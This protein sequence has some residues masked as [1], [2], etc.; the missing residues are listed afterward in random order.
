MHGLGRFLV[1]VR[2]FQRQ[3]QLDVD[4]R[5]FQPAPN[6]SPTRGEGNDLPEVQALNGE[7]LREE[8]RA[9]EA[10]EAFKKAIGGGLE[11]ANIYVKLGLALKE[12]NQDEEAAQAMQTADRLGD[13]DALS[14]FHLGNFYRDKGDKE[15]RAQAE[16]YY[17]R[18]IVLR[19]DFAEAHNNLG[20]LLQ[21][22]GEETRAVACF[23]RALASDP[24]MGSAHIHLGC[25]HLSE[26]WVEGAI[27]SFKRAL[28]I[29][30]SSVVAWI[31]LGCAYSC[32][33]WLDE[34]EEAYRRALEIQPDHPEANLNLGILLLQRGE[35]SEAWP[36]FDARWRLP[37]A[38][39]P[40]F[41]QQEWV[42]D[43][44]G[45]RTLLV[46]GDAGLGDNLQF[47]RYLPLLRQRY[48]EARIYFWCWPALYRLFEFQA[49]TWGIEVLPTSTDV[50]SLPPIDAQVVTL[51]LP[52]RMDTTLESIPADIP[53]IVVPPEGVE[54]W[55]A[56]L[57][58]LPGKKVGVVW[59]CGGFSSV[60]SRSVSLK[61]LEPLLGVGGIS[62]VSLQKGNEARQIAEEALSGSILNLMDEVE[63]FADTAAIIANLDLVI[64]VDTSVPHLAGAMGKPV[65]LLDRFNADWRW[66]LGREDSP[67]Y[68]TIRIFRQN[69]FGDWNSVMSSAA[70]ALAEW[71]AQGG[72]DPSRTFEVPGAFHALQTSGRI[73]GGDAMDCFRQGN[74]Y[75]EKGDK[76]QA[77]VFF[78]RAIALRPDF[79][80]A[81]YNLGLLLQERGEVTRA[82]ECFERVLKINPRMAGAWN[83]LGYAYYRL[84]R[85]EEA[86][87]AFRRAMEIQPDFVESEPN[88]G[89]L[90]LLRGE[91]SEG[92]PRYEARWRISGFAEKRPK[93][94]QPEWTGDPLGQRTLLVYS[95]Q[96]LGDGLQ[97]A[98]YLPLLR[99]RYP[100]ARIYFWC[101]QPLYRLFESC[102][103]A[104]GI[105]ALLPMAPGNPP[106]AP[107]GGLPPFDAH[108]S[109]MSLPWR[110]GTTLENIP[111]NVPY[112][113]PLPEWVE[114]WSA[115]LESLP[116]R[117]VGVV[118]VSGVTFSAH[119]F[120]TVRLKQLEPLFGVGGISWVSLQ[121]GDGARQIAEEALSG[122]ILNLMDEVEDFADTAAIIANLDLVIS[123]DTSVPHL[124]GAMGKPVW[125]LDRFDTDWRWL[126]D[127]EDSPWYPTMR[128]FRQNAFGD[129]DS[130]LPRVAEA[131]AGWVA[132]RGGVPSQ[133]PDG[134]GD[135]V[136]CFRQGNLY[137]EKGDK[138]KAQV[139]FERAIT[140]RPD[141]AEA[142]NNLGLLLQES[143]ELTRATE[144]FERAL[145]IRPDM[146]AAH[147]NLGNA[148]AS[149]GRMESAVDSY[150]Q[151]LEINPHSAATWNNLGNV[152]C[153]LQRTDEA[154]EAYH[155]ALEI[156]P[157]Y[158]VADFSFGMLL[159]QRGEFSEAWPRFDARWRLPGVVRPK[160]SQRE[161]TGDP[162]GRRTLLV[163]G[164]AGLGD[165]LQF[166]RYLPLLR[167][168]YPEARIYFW[169]WPALY[170]LFEFQ[171]ATW[172]IEVLPTSTD[173]SS[174]PPIDA[175]VVTL[176]L[177]WRMGTTL[178]SIPADIPYIVAPPEGVKKWSARLASLP[179]KKVGVVWACGGGHSFQPR[180]IHLKQLEPLLGVGGIS[181]VS[182]Q[183]GNSARQIAEEGLEGLSGSILN[184]MDEVEDFADTAAIIANLDL[185]ISVDT[186][187]PHLA[188]AMG[189]PVWLLDRFN[190]DWRWL[191][192]REDSPWYPTMRIF[193]QNSFGDWDSVMSCVADALADWVAQGGEIAK[194]RGER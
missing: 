26:G 74:L 156:Q 57:A 174:L 123:V 134:I 87:K 39:R 78:E 104:W 33:L 121:K 53:Y 111:A 98:R 52:W 35:F 125:L 145:S 59:A 91:F 12:T 107:S 30:S 186:S 79:A 96:G 49:A 8:D 150:K 21:E 84:H 166:A 70:K 54:K 110:M 55:S 5:R 63:D 122:S 68:P 29:D 142:H 58:S 22:N 164:D 100:E 155:R 102:A 51:S 181:W 4:I 189:K 19:P 143:G 132:Q 159:L 115:R 182:L 90:L 171:A 76:A 83:S 75:Q 161:W 151:A 193:R 92:W 119:M 190:A 173:V 141:F 44:L 17:E 93:F 131:L 124:A 45:Q 152:Y 120:R 179:G 48:P 10:I 69:S 187:V 34:A 73:G 97:F 36:R 46:Y 23:K 113:V 85:L 163:Y 56:R 116:G 47:A 153:A 66:L 13:A 16:A 175:Q 60:Q 27:D 24:D 112:I 180:S 192:G 7:L 128:I 2:L 176:S 41:S 32:L 126:L 81:H 80:E 65:W 188:G 11:T 127:R 137:R 103:A 144:C 136:T 31:N 129:W 154:E 177:P 146:E 109:L 114:K 138:A 139:F 1:L 89:L 14:C 135:A 88:L 95:E 40:K 133:M 118:W 191:L 108:I 64:S 43:P 183:K 147:I 94:S 61:Q 105:D 178:E 117:K 169:C 42:G 15:N 101:F 77:E 3:S 9:A 67:W 62:W 38:V 148:H 140:L 130:V 158:A 172:G 20:L 160:F 157:D 6:P 162:L 167:Q 82:V 170:R 165:N 184:L 50:S 99:R 86:E 71:G 28:E 185:V 37:G 106:P 18:A 72:G 194:C 25:A 168:R 149:E